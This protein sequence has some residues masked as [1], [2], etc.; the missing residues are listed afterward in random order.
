M[1]RDK[2]P[3]LERIEEMLDNELKGK[4]KSRPS[5]LYRILGEKDA[6]EVVELLL[7]G[8]LDD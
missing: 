7:S 1:N 8:K 4:M 5:S 3:M 6:E 2:K